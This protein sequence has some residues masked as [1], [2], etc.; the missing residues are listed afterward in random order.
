MLRNCHVV[1]SRDGTGL[2]SGETGN[3]G[4]PPIVFVHGYCMSK[5]LW[6]RQ[7]RA[8]ALADHFRMV[9][10]DLR[11]H[12]QSDK[13][14]TEEAYRDGRLWADDLEAVMKHY[15]VER[16]VVVAWSYGGRV[17]ND[18]M[19]H[20]G[21]E[22]LAGINYIA[23]G[24][25]SVEEAIAPGHVTMSDMFS[26]DAAVREAAEQTYITRGLDGDADPELRR[27]LEDAVRATKVR[28]RRVMRERV[29][30]YEKELAELD[31]PVL[32]SHGDCDSIVYPVHG[33]RLKAHMRRATLSLYQGHE[34]ALFLSDPSRFNQELA[35]FTLSSGAA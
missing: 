35:H 3:A 28:M 4:G 7:W 12:G 18:Y 19:R 17:V 26:P 31:L 25:I 15:G 32:I 27:D 11:G 6:K 34:H 2:A 30:D 10:F 9:F 14:D 23:A 20:V 21:A 8:A 16:P 5:A 33:E 24:T 22:R 13:P 1:R 29:I